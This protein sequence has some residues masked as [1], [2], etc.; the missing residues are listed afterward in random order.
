MI[1]GW[2]YGKNGGDKLQ[3]RKITLA[4]SA[5]IREKDYQADGKYHYT[6]EQVLI[7][8]KILFK[9]YCLGDYHDFF[10]FYGS[11]KIPGKSYFSTKKEIEKSAS[12]YIQFLMHL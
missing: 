6:L 5:G 8:F 2:S 1:Y 11:E 10:A 7:P 4:V 12:D 3:N 9:F